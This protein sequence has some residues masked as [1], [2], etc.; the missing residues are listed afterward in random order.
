MLDLEAHRAGSQEGRSEAGSNPQALTGTPREWTQSI[1]IAHGL[2]E[3]VILQKPGP[4]SQNYTHTPGP[5]V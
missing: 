4:L 2:G 1:L 5:G 3:Q